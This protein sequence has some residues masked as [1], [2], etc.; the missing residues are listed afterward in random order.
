MYTFLV[1]GQHANQTNTIK[2]K[3]DSRSIPA[4]KQFVNIL[5]QEQFEMKL[6]QCSSYNCRPIKLVGGGYST[7]TWSNHAWGLAVDMNSID[8]PHGVKPASGDPIWRIGQRVV[9]EIRTSTGAPIFR[10]G[11]T[12]STPDAMHFEIC[13]SA[14]AIANGV[15]DIQ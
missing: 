1:A 3:V 11:G 5:V 9:D 15:P 13:A 7:S 8:Y 10:W 14:A 6:G 4:W 2:L 12:W